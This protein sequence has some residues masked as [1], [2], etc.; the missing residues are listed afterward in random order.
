EAEAVR[1]ADLAG[2]GGTVELWAFE[3][4]PRRRAAEAK[5]AALKVTGRVRPA[6]K[7]S[8]EA[9]AEVLG[10]GWGP[11][12]RAQVICPA[13]FGHAARFRR[14]LYPLPPGVSARI[15]GPEAEGLVEL[16]VE[17]L[18]RRRRA[19]TA[20]IH[21]PVRRRRLPGGGGD[22]G[23]G[24]GGGGEVLSACGW[25]RWK[26]A[27]AEAWEVSEPWETPAEASL[28]AAL[29]AVA[30]CGAEGQG[31][32]FG[33]LALRLEGDWDE[34]DRDG[35]GRGLGEA[36]H[37]EIYFGALEALA[38][39]TGGVPGDRRLTPGKIVP[40]VARARTAQ[41]RMRA[42]ELETAEAS[43]PRLRSERLKPRDRGGV[44]REALEPEGWDRPPGA[45]RVSQALARLGGAALPHARS[46]EGR[47]VEGRALPGLGEA[48]AVTGGQHGNEPT[49]VVG[50]L[51]AARRLAAARIPCGVAPLENPDGWALYERLRGESG[52]WMHHAARYGALG[53]D[54]AWVEGGEAAMRARLA[55]ATGARLQISLHGYPAHEWTRP[56]TGYLPR[57]FEDWSLPRG[58][59]L[60][61]RCRKEVEAEALAA[62][63]GAAAALNADAQLRALNRRQLARF[64]AAAPEAP[65][66]RIGDVPVIV[67][68]GAETGPFDAVLIT[69]MPDETVRGAPFRLMARAQAEAALGAATAWRAARP[70]D[71]APAD[72]AAARRA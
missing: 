42:T 35:W 31:P 38:E 65:L 53:A 45:E 66:E 28:F 20:V 33:A 6:W 18:R 41:L 4:A 5:L 50:A 72:A 2:P 51:R 29:E 69:E 47:K 60:I 70:A 19:S 32:Y 26:R 34:I 12:D 15:L 43:G 1:L 37:E 54:I 49:G 21:S 63:E 10:P 68:V 52:D 30:E 11:G 67:Q 24:G 25:R 17:M 44:R 61:L 39:A 9:L 7:A 8:R 13:A 3:S 46:V 62:L 58:A 27:G 55:E 36:F 59:F 22:G 16:R 56:F 48:V 57:G 23:G 71:G 64:R 40:E 14:E